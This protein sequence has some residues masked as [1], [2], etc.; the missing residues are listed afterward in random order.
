MQGLDPRCT[1]TGHSRDKATGPGIPDEDQGLHGS[2]DFVEFGT[3]WDSE[4]RGNRDFVGFK[5]SQDSGLCVI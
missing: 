2:Q 5:T 4:L 1:E 3:S